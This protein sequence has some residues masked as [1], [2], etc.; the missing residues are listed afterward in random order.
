MKTYIILVAAFLLAASEGFA[1]G[2][3]A[4]RHMA[5]ATSGNV[6]S[7]T[8]LT[9]KGQWQI[10]GAY[11]YLHSYKHFVGTAEQPQRVA[12]GTQ[13]IN[14]SHSFDFGIS[15]NL[16]SR[17][18][19]AVNVPI[20]FN[21]RSSLY[22]H[23]G[24]SL[25]SNPLQKRFYTYSQGLGDVR[26]TATYWLF[27]PVTSMKGNIAIGIGIKAPTGNANV[28]GQFHKLDKEGKDYIVEKSVD[29]SIQLGDSGWGESIEIQGYR[30]FT[31]KMSLYFN[32][33]YLFSP[34]TLNEAT[35][36][37]VPDQFAARAGL[38]YLVMPKQ[39]VFF[40]LGGR[41]EGL[42]AIDAFGTSEGSRRPGYIISIEP[43]LVLNTPKHT[44]SFN[45]P[46]ALLRNR[47]KS[48]VDM[49]DPLGLKHGDAAFAD[50]FVSMNYGFRF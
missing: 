48:W 31:Q 38:S 43:A 33:F 9:S 20:S 47:T 13:V 2:C 10:T 6:N 46:I 45:L 18:N 39:G 34:K 1:Q 27:D 11:R 23:Y 41:I 35:G 40:N 26:F 17:L 49:Q 24:N 5:C 4:V 22:E 42:P 29:Q 36:L 19:L 12:E 14:D 37:S 8:S 15:Y 3:I 16:T 7:P 44:F 50:Y 30:S 28:Q 32:G 25:V 21:D